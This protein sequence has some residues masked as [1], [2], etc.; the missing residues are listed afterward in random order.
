MKLAHYLAARVLCPRDD[1]EKTSLALSEL[2]SAGYA[3][4]KVPITQNPVEESSQAI[5]LASFLRKESGI[6]HLFKFIAAKISAEDRQSVANESEQR[7]D[8]HLD[9]FLRFDRESWVAHRKLALTPKG[10][11]FHLTFSMAAYPKSRE[12]AAALVRQIFKTG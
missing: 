4:E 12:R 1:V 7:V 3:L 10:E 2:L 5:L 9:F 6:N 11:C 8:N